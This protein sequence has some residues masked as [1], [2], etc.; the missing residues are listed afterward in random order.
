MDSRSPVTPPEGGGQGGSRTERGLRPALAAVGLVVALAL[1][2]VL[3]GTT[4][5]LVIV[6][7]FFLI[8]L[9]L[10]L[11]MGQAGQTSLGQTLFMAIG[12][13]GAGLLALK[14]H[15]PT[16]LAAAGMAVVS[17][18]VAAVLG[19]AFL[20]LR[21]YYL[22]LATLGLAVITQNLATGLGPL[23]GGPS[24][25]VGIPSLR[26]GPIVFFSDQANYYLVLV[27]CGLG[28]W[29][30]GN[31]QRGQTG[32]ALS[33]IAADPQAAA[34][35]GI[36]PSR[37]KTRAFVVSAVFASLG[38]SLYAFY[39]RFISPEMVGVTVAFAI[40]IMLTLGGARTLAGP[41]IGALLLQG[42]PM[43]GQRV[44]L[45]EPLVAGLVLIVVVTYFPL[46]IWGGTRALIGRWRP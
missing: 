37:Y 42:L 24:G 10:N 4:S 8:V 31:L 36:K 7:V 28:A 40:V 22:A 38:G 5:L 29:F 30:V 13:Y 45:W 1:P 3:P 19:A 32:R 11:L 2:Y 43:A 20:R 15:W 14:L 27:V 18:G 6:G 17:A 46:G 44:A 34:M 16:A 41:L 35:L 25:L 23:T 26:L 39:F 33:A 12:G 21:G 9:G